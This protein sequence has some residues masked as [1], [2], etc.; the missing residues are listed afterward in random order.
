[1]P[2]IRLKEYGFSG[3]GNIYMGAMHA[4][5]EW[6]GRILC[7]IGGDR[8]HK[9]GCQVALD[10]H[11]AIGIDLIRRAEHR[12]LCGVALETGSFGADLFK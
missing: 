10:S 9:F 1:V 7:V 4:V 2:N 8:L 6:H 3:N 5:V 12:I 11:R